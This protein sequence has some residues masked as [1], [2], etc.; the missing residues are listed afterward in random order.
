MAQ[1]TAI[2][3][4]FILLLLVFISLGR[5]NP[6]RRNKRYRRTMHK[7]RKNHEQ[8]LTLILVCL[9]FMVSY[10][11]L[12]KAVDINNETSAEPLEGMEFDDMNSA[13]MAKTMMM[14]GGINMNAAMNSA[15]KGGGGGGG[16]AAMMKKFKSQFS[17]KGVHVDMRRKL[18]A[19]GISHQ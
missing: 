1:G 18:Q 15:M 10:Y 14:G 4:F 17:G 9:S 8:Y 16:K 2:I 12:S 7:V 5:R 13:A 3:Y 6:L 19:M 11:S